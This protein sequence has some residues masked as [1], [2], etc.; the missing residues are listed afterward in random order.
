MEPDIGEVIV[1]AFGNNTFYFFDERIPSL[2]FIRW[3]KT[4]A[5]SQ[6][7][8]LTIFPLTFQHSFARLDQNLVVH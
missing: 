3:K 4:F 2:R 5:S 8:Y 7:K 6:N 1:C